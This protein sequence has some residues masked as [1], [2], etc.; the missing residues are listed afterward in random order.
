MKKIV[1]VLLG[2]VIVLFL[3]IW[4]GLRIKP[5]SFPA[6]GLQHREVETAPLPEGLPAPVER[7]YREIYG[8][9]VPVVDTAVVSGRADLRIMGI[10]FPS[11]FRFVHDAGHDYRHYIESTVF[12]F[13]VMK[14]N[15]FFLDGESR[16][17]LPVGV[18]ENEPKVNQAANLGLWAEAAWFPSVWVTD[19]RVRWE[20]VDEVTALLVVPFGREEDRFTAHFDPET[21]LLHKLESMRWKDAADEEKTLWTNEVVE[22]NTVDGYTVPTV[23]SLTWAD[24]GTPWAVFRVDELVYNVGVKDYIRVR[25]I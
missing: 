14:I 3:L 24:E 15:E 12:G 25:G 18:V 21:G 11:R 7:F 20:P 4:M 19:P 2:V 10:T 13:P 17:E 5:A 9:E 16:L 8:D 22:W 6:V 1:L 23:A